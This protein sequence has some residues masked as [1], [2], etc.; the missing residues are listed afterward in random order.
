M[1][2]I[3]YGPFTLYESEA[4]KKNKEIEQ[5]TR[6]LQLKNLEY[7]LDPQAQL[8]KQTEIAEAA[9]QQAF[10]PSASAVAQSVGQKILGQSVGMQKIPGTNLE[11][12]VGTPS[13]M[14]PSLLQ[15]AVGNVRALREYANMATDPE[16]KRIYSDLAV[17]AE[18][19]LNAKAKELSATDLAFEGNAAAALRYADQFE[20]LVDQ[21]GTFELMNPRGSALLGQLPL[22]MAI[23]YAKIVDPSSVAR[24]GEVEVAKRYMLPTGLFT[25]NETAKQ[26]IRNFR[27]DVMNRADEYA[28]ATGRNI[29]FGGKQ[30]EPSK[31][32]DSQGAIPLIRDPSGRF[33]PAR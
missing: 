4:Y 13:A 12:P 29:Q 2:R 17:S 21:Y 26:A 18:K 20:N 25:R 1:D 3:S 28:R 22:Q 27:N 16:E 14:L 10:D 23:S 32:Q 30:R 24:E 19:G 33:V 15:T 7:S 9:S 11:V 8:R 6:E 5:R 31:Q